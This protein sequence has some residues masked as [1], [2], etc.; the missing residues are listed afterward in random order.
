M[1]VAT[2]T[3][4]GQEATK[5]GHKQ[6]REEIALQILCATISGQS[7][8]SQYSLDTYVPNPT[9]KLNRKDATRATH[10]AFAMADYFIQERDKQA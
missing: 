2:L 6:T 5:E 7:G 1:V 8:G 4:Q 3:K 10:Q 9:N